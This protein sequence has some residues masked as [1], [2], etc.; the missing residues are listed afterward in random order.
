MNENLNYDVFIYKEYNIIKENEVYN[1]RL[2]FDQ[3][4]I[5]FKLKKV[6]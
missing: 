2:E 1:L 4:N 6:R 3:I 5:N